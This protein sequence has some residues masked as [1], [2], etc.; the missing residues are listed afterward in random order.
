NIEQEHG[1]RGK[2]RTRT[3]E[4]QEGLEAMAKEFMRIKG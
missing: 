3:K 4:S 2:E 1:A